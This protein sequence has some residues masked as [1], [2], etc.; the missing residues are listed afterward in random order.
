[1]RR[2]VAYAAAVWALIFGVLHFVWAGGWYLGLDPVAA[3]AAFAVPWKLAYDLVAGVMCFVAVFVALAFVTP[4]GRRV[5]R[6]VLM[7]I[8]WIGIGLLVLRAVASIVQVTYF[9][10]T[11]R[12]TWS[13]L[14]IWEPWFYLGA[15]LFALTL[16]QFR[17][18]ERS[19]TRLTD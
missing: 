16:W 4:W 15:T 12:F 6:R 10:V 17:Q 2:W 11:G 19:P 9:A 14:G 18:R 1:V 8:A 13:A 7:P 5:P 3:Q